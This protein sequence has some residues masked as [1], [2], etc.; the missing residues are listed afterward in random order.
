MQ[1]QPQS[2]NEREETRK[3]SPEREDFVRFLAHAHRAAQNK[4][5]FGG[6]GWVYPAQFGYEDS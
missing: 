1:L 6:Q 4:L 5:R 2:T 3:D